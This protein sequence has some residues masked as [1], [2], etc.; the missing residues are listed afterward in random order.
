MRISRSTAGHIGHTGQLISSILAKYPRDLI[1]IMFVTTR[2]DALV[3]IPVFIDVASIRVILK[4]LRKRRIYLGDKLVSI[5]QDELIAR[6][7][8]YTMRRIPIAIHGDIVDVVCVIDPRGMP[9]R[10]PGSVSAKGTFESLG[11][12]GLNGGSQ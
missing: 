10:Y 7:V 11:C 3:G 5:N 4:Q 9:R 6:R 8:I 12:Q 1:S 2:A